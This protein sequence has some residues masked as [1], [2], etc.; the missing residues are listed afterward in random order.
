MN[1]KISQFELTNTLYDQDLLTVVQSNENKNITVSGLTTSL[2]N[3]F[4]TNDELSTISSKID[5]VN[6]KVEDN[7]NDLSNKIEE[8]DAAV[9]NNVTS[10]VNSYYDV[11]N[12]KIIVLDEKH[13]KDMSE[14]NLTVQDWID[15]ID[16]RSTVDQLH[17]ALNRLTVAENTI[18]ALAEVIANGGG[19]GSTPGYHT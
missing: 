13:D 11:L 4:S 17:D 2:S 5:S 18:T 16:N 3:T 8:G 7:Y 19:S 12:N 1:K 14:V 15:D 10:T 9:T 6:I